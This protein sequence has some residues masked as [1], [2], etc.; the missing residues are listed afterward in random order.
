[1]KSAK[2]PLK[3]IS[4]GSYLPQQIVT[5]LEVD[6]KLGI[7]PGK[8]EQMTG[9]AERRYVTHETASE[10]GAYAI[11]AALEK[12]GIRFEEI[13]AIICASGSMEQALPCTAA[14]IQ[15]ALKR[16][17]TTIP[18]FDVN[19]TCLS[20]VTALD[21]A[22]SL[23][24]TDRFKTIVIVSTEIA[25]VGLNPAQHEAY[26]LFGD[27]AAAAIVQK[28]KEGETSGVMHAQMNTYSEGADHCRILGGGTKYHPKTQTPDSDKFLFS[29][30]G[31][32]VFRLVLETIPE[33]FERFIK[34][35]GMTLD[36][37]QLIIPHQASGN[38]MELVRRK[39]GID[40]SKYMDILAKHGNMIAAS[41]PLALHM[42]IEQGRVKRGDKIMLLG[43]SAGM[44][45]GSVVFEY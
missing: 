36:D 39:L 2:R 19:A 15:R 11:M 14:L 41:I 29:M 30:E 40:P 22:S 1:M 27:G 43:T 21:L 24:A 32:K 28:P 16:P 34:D 17:G 10:M 13:D 3:I 4:T 23:L 42:A 44:S 37:L 6:R 33:F 26:A 12:S 20:F 18:C 31:K 7:A 25:S 45:I 35:S 9:I 38:G 5:G 8:S